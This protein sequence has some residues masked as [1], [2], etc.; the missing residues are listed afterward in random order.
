MIEREL[1]PR[2]ASAFDARCSMPKALSMEIA[3]TA[4][5][6]SVIL[7]TASGPRT[8][9]R[10]GRWCRR[11]HRIGRVVVGARERHVDEPG[12]LLRTCTGERRLD[13]VLGYLVGP[14]LGAAIAV[15]CAVVGR[16]ARDP[17]SHAAGARVLTPGR[18]EEKPK[19][20]RTSTRA[21]W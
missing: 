16:D 6:V 21:R 5:L 1:G 9:A 20:A 12:A 18:A 13:R 8:S 7:G 2:Y 15:G 17:I 19:L 3:L 10:S 11:V 4:V 14:L